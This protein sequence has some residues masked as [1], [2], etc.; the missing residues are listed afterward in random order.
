MKKRIITL[1]TSAVFSILLLS[2]AACTASEPQDKNY[3][4]S[5]EI[6]NTE[7]I[8][9]TETT[10]KPE[11]NI[12]LSDINS[13]YAVILDAQTGEVIAEKNGDASIF[14]ASMTKIMT[15]ILAIENFSD[16]NTYVTVP[17]DAIISAANRGGSLAGFYGGETV[18]PMDLI[19][20]IL[21]PSGCE[22]SIAVGMLISG[23][24]E[25]FVELM[26]QKAQELG[27]TETHFDN[28][29]G[30]HTENHYSTAHD[31]AKL[32]LYASSNEIFR[33]IDT[34]PSYITSGGKTLT[35]TMFSNINIIYGNT[36]VIGGR[37]LGGKT[38]TTNEAGSCLC[39]F[40]EL[41]GKE[42]ILCTAN[43][44]YSGLN[45][46]D[47]KTIYNRLGNALSLSYT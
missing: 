26:N 6:N 12:D 33:Q 29:T 45:V 38:G 34:T 19:Y 7:K 41:F 47:A 40:A 37:I 36:D 25:A 24:E 14:P 11:L 17:S 46:S 43:A 15:A 44:A 2:G 22:C 42:Y 1:L 23:S 18:T 20:G 21:L 13:Q 32:M 4:S 35:S 9:I 5:S 31:M 10:A 3:S 30:L 16:L 39:S 8:I 28:A 27:M